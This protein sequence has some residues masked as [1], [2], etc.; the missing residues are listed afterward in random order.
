MLGGLCAQRRRPLR[1]PGGNHLPQRACARAAASHAE[2]PSRKQCTLL[3]GQIRTQDGRLRLPAGHRARR[4]WLLQAGQADAVQAAAGH[5]PDPERTCVCPQGT[6]LKNGAA[7]GRAAAVHAAARQIRTQDGRCVCPRGTELRNGAL[8]QGRAD[9]RSAG[10]CPAMIRTQNGQCICPRGT[11]LRN[12]ACRKVEHAAVQAAA[13]HDPD[14]E[15]QLRLPEGYGAEERR[16]PQGRAA[17]GQGVQAPRPG[18]APERPLRLPE[19]Y[20]AEGRGL[21]Q[22][23]AAAGQA[24]QDPWSGQAR[25]RPLRLSG[26]IRGEQWRVPQ[27]S[28]AAAAR[29]SSS[30]SRA[31]R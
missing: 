12:G 15:R 25:Q 2:P 16:L 28:Q 8:P 21:P 11:E 5:D 1:L 22:G 30:S 14:P 3:P 6:E 29:R 27:D 24:V 4:Q 7:E 10:C 13:R 23:R 9:R 20:R 18:Q 19:G 26:R 31:S 17:A